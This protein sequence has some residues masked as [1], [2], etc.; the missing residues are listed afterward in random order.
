M[1]QLPHDNVLVRLAPSPIHGIGVFAQQ[2]IAAGTNVFANDRREI[3][4]VPAGQIAELPLAD[5]QRAFHDDFAI[6]KDGLL[7]CPDSFDLLSPAWYVNEP[8]ERDEPNLVPSPDFDLLA[9]RDIAAG[10]ELTV[11]YRSFTA[12]P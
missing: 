4:W 2:P 8:A 1:S 7:G 11:D 9:A 10:E 5:F 12:S 6:R 3:V